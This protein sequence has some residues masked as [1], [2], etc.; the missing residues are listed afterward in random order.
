VA[1]SGYLSRQ[2]QDQIISPHLSPPHIQECLFMNILSKSL[3]DLTIWQVLLDSPC[4]KWMDTC[5]TACR[6]LSKPHVHSS[7]WRMTLGIIAAPAPAPADA[8]A[9]LCVCD[10]LNLTRLTSRLLSSIELFQSWKFSS[11]SSISSISFTQQPPFLTRTPIHIPLPV[12][13]A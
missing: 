1:R 2:D 10:F 8:N 11:L 3:A 6:V 13:I 4:D 5:A 7:C 9:G 12:F